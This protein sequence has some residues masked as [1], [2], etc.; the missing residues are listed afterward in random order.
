LTG[1]AVDDHQWWVVAQG[2]VAVDAFLRDHPPAGSKLSFS[3]SSGKKGTPSSQLVEGFE[4][5]ALRGRLSTRELIVAVTPLSGGGSGV[6]VDAED[7]WITPRPASERIPRQVARL[8]V[9]L[10]RRAKRIAGP[11]T[12]TSRRQIRRVRALIDGLPAAQSGVQAC[13]EDGGYDVRLTFMSASRRTLAV[14]NA[15]PQGCEG[16]QLTLHGRPQPPLTSEGFPGSGRSPRRPLVHQL[17]RALGL[18][19]T[20]ALGSL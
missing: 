13:P 14:V 6:R 20:G 3:G 9:Q 19:L 5:P 17:D 8:E 18:R 4:W 15:D 1:N 11:F 7:V 12:F 16:V 2:Y 10:L